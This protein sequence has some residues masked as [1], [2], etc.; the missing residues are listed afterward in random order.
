[1]KYAIEFPIRIN[2]SKNEIYI[3]NISNKLSNDLIYYIQPFT[4]EP[5][6]VQGHGLGL[7]IVNK[8]LSLHGFELKH[9]YKDSHNIFS[10]YF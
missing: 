6:Q 7:N 2:S 5:N 8:I 10:I 3:E 9:K 4:R 1:M